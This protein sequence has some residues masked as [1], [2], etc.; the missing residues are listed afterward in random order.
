MNSDGKRFE[1]LG[2]ILR[3]LVGQ[4]APE[5]HLGQA[6][7]EL[8]AE[9]WA[10]AEALPEGWMF[11]RTEGH[12]VRFLTPQYVRCKDLEQAVQQMKE[13]GVKEDQIETFKSHYKKFSFTKVKKVKQ[14]VMKEDM[15]VKEWKWNEDLPVGWTSSGKMLRDPEGRLFANIIRALKQLVTEESPKE[16]FE[17][18]SAVLSS[19]GWKPAMGLPEGWMVRNGRCK[20][21]PNWTR[22]SF[23]SPQY[24]FLESHSRAMQFLKQNGTTE[25]DLRL[26]RTS[27]QDG[28]EPEAV[29]DPS[30][31]SSLETKFVWME[32]ETLPAGW[33][34]TYHTP[35]LVSMKDK[36]F[37]KLLSPESRCLSSRPQALRWG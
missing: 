16:T 6:R 7:R 25:D 18:L 30:K 27:R 22:K 23:L 14:L 24:D 28:N 5:E 12:C 32:D 1:N 10:G 19:E 35:N 31:E 4:G 20:S 11:K 29:V 26:L 8:E 37:I 33:K 34:I 21:R 9:G 3:H 36:L 15:D 17:K 2:Q 13:H